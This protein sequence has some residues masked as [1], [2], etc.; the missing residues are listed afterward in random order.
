[1][2]PDSSVKEGAYKSIYKEGTTER[3]TGQTGEYYILASGGYIKKATVRVLT[4]HA[5]DEP[6]ITEI[7]TENDARAERIVFAGAPGLPFTFEQGDGVTTLTLHNTKLPDARRIESTLFSGVRFSQ[8]GDDLVVTLREADETSVF[9]MDILNREDATVLYAKRAPQRTKTVGKPLED[10]VVVLDPGHGGNDPGALSVLGLDAPAEREVNLA[11]ATMLR[12][13][14]EQLGATVVMTRSSN[15]ETV[16]LY[17]RM[18][19]SE[20][21]LPDFYMSLHHNSVPET[22]DASRGIGVEAYY[23]DEYAKTLCETVVSK[24][25]AANYD[26]LQR[27]IEQSY[28]TVTR[29]R[30]APSILVEI[31]FM[32]NPVEYGRLCDTTEIYKTANAIACALLEIVR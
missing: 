2:F 26:R 29:M 14:L 15:E 17:E 13:R 6:E 19:I 22:A 23:Y 16:S 25:A 20:A 18:A 5:P 4:D 9:A 3:A 12:Q 10:L 1:M 11:D 8:E 30:Y 32:P 27:P 31:G 24:I 28:Y 21:A 7:T